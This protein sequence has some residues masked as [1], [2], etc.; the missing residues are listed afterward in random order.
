MQSIRAYTGLV[1]LCD[2]CGQPCY[3]DPEGGL[4]PGGVSI[5]RW[6]HFREQWDGVH[7]NH[8]PYAGE[9]LGAKLDPSSVDDIRELYPNTYP[10]VIF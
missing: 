3:L 8:F 1:D 9:P 5:S 4:G 2:S 7:C 6:L 10:E